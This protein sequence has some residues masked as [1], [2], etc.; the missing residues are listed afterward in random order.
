MLVLKGTRKILHNLR[1]NTEEVI[2]NPGS[3]PLVD[4]ESLPARQEA[5]GIPSRGIEA[6]STHLGELV[7][8]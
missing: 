4:L 6:G 3:D 8:P 2:W 7:L 5:M 1:P